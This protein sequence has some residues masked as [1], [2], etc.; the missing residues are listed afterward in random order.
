MVGREPEQIPKGYRLAAFLPWEMP[1]ETSSFTPFAGISTQ[2][3]P[4]AATLTGTASFVFT[5]VDDVS[6]DEAPDSSPCGTSH[7]I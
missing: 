4:R 1:R 7:S 3:R 5:P 6:A 2:Q